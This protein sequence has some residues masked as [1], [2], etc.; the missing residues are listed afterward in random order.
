MPE[1][2]PAHGLTLLI[3]QA[4]GRGRGHR[5]T[6]YKLHVCQDGGYRVE[7]TLAAILFWD[8]GGLARWLKAHHC[9]YRVAPS[10]DVE[11][12]HDSELCMALA[13][14]ANRTYLTVPDSMAPW[15]A[16]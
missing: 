8:F 14:N 4:M 7:Q 6:Y 10:P 3:G 12:I 9:S 13:L 11:E 2:A 16:C 5:V 15:R 1:V